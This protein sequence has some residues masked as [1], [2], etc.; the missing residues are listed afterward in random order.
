MVWPL[1]RA[2][3]R[4]GMAIDFV[5]AAEKAALA[6]RWLGQP[7]V[8]VNIEQP[9]FTSL[10][11]GE[12]ARASDNDRASV[13]PDVALVVSFLVEPS[14]SAAERWGANARA[15]FPNADIVLVGAP[16]SRARD[17]CWS[18]F[19]VA[20][21]G[22]VTPAHPDRSRTI[23][24]HVGAGGEAKRWPLD[25]FVEV[26][27]ILSRVHAPGI[28]LIA[29]EVERER[30]N[31]GERAIFTAAQGRVIDTLDALAHTLATSPLVIAS[32]TGPGH[33]AAQLGVPTLS[34]FGP[35]NP[36]TW[37]PRGPCVRVLT[38]PSPAPMTWLSVDQ[39]VNEATTLLAHRDPTQ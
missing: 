7:I 35:T 10:W 34:L 14:S 2:L 12:P 29:G 20:A 21:R 9:R 11:R 24:L 25:R 27:S 38:P 37:S 17:E 3:V 16:G 23:M 31:E 8:A 4:Q 22:Y 33:L 6:A 32:D 13:D 19:A 30:F 28:Q 1:L 5:S 15:S 26:A 39:V 18:R 36:S